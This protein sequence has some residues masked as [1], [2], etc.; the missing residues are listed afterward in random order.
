ML[1]INHAVQCIHGIESQQDV[2]PALTSPFLRIEG[3]LL[4]T[5]TIEERVS[6]ALR[7]NTLMDAVELDT[8][9]YLYGYVEEPRQLVTDTMVA[10]NKLGIRT[11]AFFCDCH[12]ADFDVQQTVHIA[13]Q[14]N[15]TLCRVVLPFY[16]SDFATWDTWQWRIFDS[17]LTTAL[18]AHVR[19]PFKCYLKEGDRHVPTIQ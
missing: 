17:R 11:I 15:I 19:Q 18:S 7:C 16:P 1:T 4:T 2:S 3:V 5:T 9:G 12:G 13:K 8:H 14:F 10:L 6:V